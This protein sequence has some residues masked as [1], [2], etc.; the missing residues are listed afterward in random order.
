MNDELERIRKEAVVAKIGY[1]SDICLDRL[2]I[3]K[4]LSGQLVSQMRVDANSFI[5]SSMDLKPF[6][7][8]WPLFFSHNPIHIR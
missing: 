1:Y 6:V 3:Q 2:R 7:R 5:H 4:K 8:L